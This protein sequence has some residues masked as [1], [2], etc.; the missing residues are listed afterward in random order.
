MSIY[1]FLNKLTLNAKKK[2][3]LPSQI[4]DYEGCH[5]VNHVGIWEWK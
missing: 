2:H 3:S 4:E 5:I 1:F